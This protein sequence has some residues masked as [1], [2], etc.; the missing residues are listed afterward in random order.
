MSDDR[1][2]EVR[3]GW[4]PDQAAKPK[5]PEKPQEK[6]ENSPAPTDNRRAS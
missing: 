1:K 3:K 5:P 6:Q 4:Q 2:E